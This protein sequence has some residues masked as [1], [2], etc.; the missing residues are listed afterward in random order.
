LESTTWPGTTVEVVG[1]MLER[2]GLVLGVDFHLAFSPERIDPGNAVYTLQNTPKVVGGMTA[3]CTRRA[4]EFLRRA[5]PQT[6]GS[7]RFP[8]G[9]AFGM[10]EPLG[11]VTLARG[12]DGGSG[13]HASGAISELTTPRWRAPPPTLLATVRGSPGRCPR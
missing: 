1:P 6:L 7:R 8:G 13:A 12:S 10:A 11:K 4:A 9:D 5:S 3:E 2:T